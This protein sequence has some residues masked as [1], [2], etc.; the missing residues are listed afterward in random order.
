LLKEE[1]TQSQI[2]VNLERDKSTVSREIA[3][4]SGL[5]EYRPRQANILAEERSMN[6]R[7]ARKVKA[8]DW[9]CAKSYW[10]DQ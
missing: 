6:S 5:R 9:L 2:A 1:L 4:N 3:R 8:S 10:E 7:N